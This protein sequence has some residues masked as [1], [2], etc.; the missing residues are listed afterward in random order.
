MVCRG[1]PRKDGDEDGRLQVEEDI[2]V[3][4]RNRTARG[5]A[6]SRGVGF[7]VRVRIACRNKEGGGCE[8]EDRECTSRG[9]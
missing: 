5:R 3:G 6:C 8:G 1:F 2:W 7:G 9:Y 4:I